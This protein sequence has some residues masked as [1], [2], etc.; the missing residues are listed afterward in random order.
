MVSELL[1]LNEPFP[2]SLGLGD[3][4]FIYSEMKAIFVTEL[5]YILSILDGLPSNN[6]C[7]VLCLVLKLQSHVCLNICKLYP[8]RM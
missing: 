1:D 7:S 4:K 5:F 6:S 3:A 2:E 8:W